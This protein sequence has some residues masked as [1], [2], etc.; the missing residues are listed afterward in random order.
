MLIRAGGSHGCFFFTIGEVNTHSRRGE[1]LCV[2]LTHTHT[3]SDF[4]DALLSLILRGSSAHE[5]TVN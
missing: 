5:D 4:C 2:S 3:Q 1:S